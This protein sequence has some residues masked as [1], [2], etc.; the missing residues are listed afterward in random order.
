MDAGGCGWS[1]QRMLPDGPASVQRDFDGTPM[2]TDVMHD[3]TC[4]ELAGVLRDR[5]DGF[6]QML[7]ISGDNKRDQAFYE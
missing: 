6:M 7:M 1:A 5:N 3:D 2:P 4:R